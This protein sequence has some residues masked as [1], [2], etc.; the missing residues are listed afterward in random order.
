MS[1]ED[2]I[3]NNIKVTIFTPTYNRQARII[4]LFESLKRQTC[5]SFEWIIIDDGTDETDKY[6]DEFQKTA[7][8]LI[9]YY[10]SNTERGISRAMNQMVKIARGLL[11]MKVDDDDVLTDDA[12]ESVI[13]FEE[14]IDSSR[15]RYAGVS[16]LRSF[17]DGTV[18]GGSWRNKESHVDAT[19]FERKKYGLCGD[20]AEAYYLDVLKK[21]GPMPTVNGEHYTWESVLWDRIAH[22]GLKI[23]WF[24]K[25]IYITEYLPD[26]ATANRITARITSFE[27]YTIMVSEKCAYEEVPFI[28]RLILS[29]RYFEL[30]KSLG[31]SY[32]DVKKYFK[33]NIGIARMGYVLSAVTKFIPSRELRRMETNN[34]Y[35][36]STV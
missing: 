6:V 25:V 17:P 26:G 24:N 5:K 22:A 33:N 34:D 14:T 18:I 35:N 27:T 15:G 29:C 36:K 12:I 16:G 2:V 19:N 11:V 21:Y 30:A 13:S 28:Q 4:F 23:R 20:K 8:F 10:K 9:R 31:K 32:R 7:N 1:L 3:M